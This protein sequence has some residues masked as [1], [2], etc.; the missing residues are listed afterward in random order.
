MRR[1]TPLEEQVVGTIEFVSSLNLTNTTQ[2]IPLLD[3]LFDLVGDIEMLISNSTLETLV[4]DVED[5]ITHLCRLLNRT[6][7]L[8]MRGAAVEAELDRIGAGGREIQTALPALINSLMQLRA[9]FENIS[10]IIFESQEF[11]SVNSTFYA[12]LARRALE[13]SDAAGFLVR[14]NVTSILNE[15]VLVLEAFNATLDENDVKDANS[16]LLE[17]VANINSTASEMQA[18]I[19]VASERLCGIEN[20]TCLECMNE[21]CEIC[22]SGIRCDG[23]IATADLASNISSATL[24]VADDLLNQIMTE[25]QSL[26]ELLDR[27][28]R[29]KMG[30]VEAA[31]FV[32][33]LR[34]GSLEL[35][36]N[37]QSLTNELERELNSTRVDPDDISRLENATLSLQLELLPDE[38]IA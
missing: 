31:D 28:R 18:F 27:A 34:N 17:A 7:D 35:I 32:N 22:P 37:V 6:D 14:E 25:I 12:E 23:L 38:V 13:R 2:D 15:T 21:T 26:E 4:V 24:V 30:A 20:G 8:I 16:R 11:I 33:E 5:F 9:D 10:T 19:A 3:E 36:D 29:V 1:I